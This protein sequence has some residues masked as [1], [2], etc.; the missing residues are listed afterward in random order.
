MKQVIFE[1]YGIEVIGFIKVSSKVFKLKIEDGFL[2][3]KFTEN[4]NFEMTFE[5]I[6]TLGVDCFVDIIKNN[7]HRILSR[8]NDAYFFIMPWID[9]DLAIVKELKLQCFFETLAYV[10]SH[11]FFQYNV[12]KDYYSRQINDLRNIIQERQCYYF[13]M[14]KSYESM[15]YRSPAGW[16][17]VLNYCRIV[18]SFEQALCY[19]EQYEQLV[20]CLDT[21]R[22]SLVYNNFNYNH[23]VMNQKTLISIDKTSIDLCIY[24]IFRMYQQGCDLLYDLDTVS[25]IYLDHVKLLPQEKVLLSCLLCIV[26][27]VEIDKDEVKNVIKMS[28]L[29]YYLD[30]IVCFN[31]L[32]ICE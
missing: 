5:H 15:Q 28:R 27:Y 14:M 10:H 6:K 1:Q 23:V 12:S 13:E 19:L 17:F 21:V 26:P 3:L 32:L 24:D 20:Q 25:K 16:I 30:S 11:T 7:Q 31:K 9:H 22:V 8:F 18:Q 29:L 4:I 2:C